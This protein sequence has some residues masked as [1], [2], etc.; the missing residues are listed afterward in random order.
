MYQYISTF[1]AFL[2]LILTQESGEEGQ[3]QAVIHYRADETMYVEAK[4][5]GFEIQ[6]TRVG[7]FR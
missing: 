3:E 6:P 1:L 2:F 5:P 4:G 7:V